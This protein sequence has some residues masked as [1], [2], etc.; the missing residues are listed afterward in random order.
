[1]K[2]LF[3]LLALVAYAFSEDCEKCEANC[4]AK[5]QG[6]LNRGKLIDCIADCA[7]NC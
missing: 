3:V 7:F 6:I 1:M 2:K 5:Y 4:R